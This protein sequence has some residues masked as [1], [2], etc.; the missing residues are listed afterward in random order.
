MTGWFLQ[1]GSSINGHYF[2]TRMNFVEYT[3][4]A[5]RRCANDFSWFTRTTT[6]RIIIDGHYDLD[7]LNRSG[8]MDDNLVG[9][10]ST[11]VTW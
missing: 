7:F 5:N 1:E 4:F 2:I 8:R 10:G 9:I 11:D 3:V 6:V